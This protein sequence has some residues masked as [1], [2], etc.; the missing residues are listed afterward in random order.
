[1]LRKSRTWIALL[2]SVVLIVGCFPTGVVALEAAV[3][4]EIDSLD[5]SSGNDYDEIVATND[6]NQDETTVKEIVSLR[7]ENVKHFDM[8]DGTYQAVTYG[9]PVHR[10]DETGKWQDIDNTLTL[11]RISTTATYITNDSRVKFASEYASSASLLTLSENGYTIEMSFVSPSKGR[12]S[13][14]KINN[15]VSR[16]GVLSESHSFKD[17]DELTVV[18]DTGSIKYENVVSG[19]DLEYILHSNDVKENIIVNKICDNYTYTFGLKTNNLIAELN[20]SG[21]VY[22]RDTVKGNIVYVIPT[23]YMYDSNGENSYEVAY[24]LN[25]IKNGTYELTITADEKWINAAGR[26]FPVVIDPTILSE[27]EL[28]YDTYVNAIDATAKNTDYGS[29]PTMWISNPYRIAFVKSTAMPWL[30]AGATVTNASLKVAYYYYSGITGGMYITAHQMMKYWDETSTWNTLSNNGQNTVLGISPMAQSTTYLGAATS[31]PQWASIDITNAAKWWYYDDD[32][33]NHENYGVALKYK[34]GNSSVILHSYDAMNG[35]TP[36]FTVTYKIPNGVYA[37]GKANTNVYIKNNTLKNLAWVYQETFTSP[38]T[39]EDDR[40]YMFKIAYR[41]ATD[42]YVIRSMS[43]N[44]II[45]YFS[46]TNNAPVAGK[47]TVSGNPATDSNISTGYTWKI[48][49]TSDGYEY[50]WYQNE[51]ATYYLRSTSNEG[52]GPILSCTTNKNNTGTKWSF[53]EYNGDPIDGIGRLNFDNCLLPGETYIHQ[54]YMYSSTIGRNGPVS[55]SSGNTDVFTVN[56]SSGLITAVSPGNANVWVTYPGAPLMWGKKS[57]ITKV[58][59]I[60]CCNDDGYFDVSNSATSQYVQCN[61]SEEIKRS[62]WVFE[63]QGSGYYTIRNYVTGYYLKNSSNTLV[64]TEYTGTIFSNEFLWKVIRM[65]DGTYKFQSKYTPSYFISEENTNHSIVDPD[66]VL[67][68]TNDGTRQQWNIIPKFF[69]VTIYNYYDYTF[70]VRFDGGTSSSI[71]TKNEIESRQNRLNKYLFS[72]YGIVA[73]NNTPSR[74]V[75]YADR[76]HGVS[77][78]NTSTI[79]SICNHDQEKLCDG[80]NGLCEHILTGVGTC[81]ENCNSPYHHNNSRK[82]H[83]WYAHEHSSPEADINILWTGQK[84]CDDVYVPWSSGTHI[85][86]TLYRSENVGYWEYSAFHEVGHSLGAKGDKKCSS[87][88]CVMSSAT[89]WDKRFELLQNPDNS[90]FCDKCMQ[91][92]REDVH[93]SY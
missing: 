25:E 19:V 80:R 76:C 14:A 53:Y 70:Q 81:N 38:P 3:D 35:Y 42:D 73:I 11:Q 1:M 10:K 23:P 74:R 39:D 78:I 57:I 75:S 5:V 34:S 50:I 26:D 16:Q 31:Y 21:A 20:E 92:I 66:I 88:S 93:N 89:S 43:N 22:L 47:V 52:G 60:A 63:N 27:T 62:V 4:T 59:Q 9:Y 15:S 12:V 91:Q 51:T 40:D 56:S 72:E 71:N 44:E 2:L 36:Y 64:H 79:D 49:T 45:L 37:I 61:D 68:N 55:Y 54:A 83:S 30:P 33:G 32:T 65:D 29:E 90:T 82:I 17:K 13:A 69:E 18:N 6:S 58:V 67:T 28:T 84:N 85:T 24:Q 86:A 46:E 77:N 87:T 8:G 41:A 7:S 48:T